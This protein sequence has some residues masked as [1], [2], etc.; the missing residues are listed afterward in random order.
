MSHEWTLMSEPHFSQSSSFSEVSS[1]RHKAFG[2]EPSFGENPF[3]LLLLNLRNIHRSA[4]FRSFRPR[5]NYFERFS[6]LL[7]DRPGDKEV[8]SGRLR[9]FRWGG[10]DYWRKS[11]FP[12]SLAGVMRSIWLLNCWHLLV[13]KGGEGWRIDEKFLKAGFVINGRRESILWVF[14]NYLLSGY[15]RFNWGGS[16]PGTSNFFKG[17]RR[18]RC[19]AVAINFF[20]KI[21]EFR[22]FSKQLMYQ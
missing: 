11:Y 8:L 12:A 2:A 16:E 6:R 20:R 21:S 19:G 22:T 18:C 10:M 1:S 15:Y 3:D 14:W 4:T 7:R 17:S 5:K 9:V 13:N